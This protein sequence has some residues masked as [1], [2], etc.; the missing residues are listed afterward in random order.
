M[1]A[2]AA[3]LAAVEKLLPLVSALL[4]RFGPVEKGRALRHLQRKIAD[5]AEQAEADAQ[6]RGQSR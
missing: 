5:M 1:S 3:A 2:I 4:E 6:L